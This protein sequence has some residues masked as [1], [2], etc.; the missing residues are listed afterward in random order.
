MGVWVL[1]TSFDVSFPGCQWNAKV[2]RGTVKAKHVKATTESYKANFFNNDISKDLRLPKQ[3]SSKVHLGVSKNRGTPKWMVYNGIPYWNDDLG[4]PL[5]SET[6]ISTFLGYFCCYHLKS[7]FVGKITF[8]LSW[9]PLQM[10]SGINGIKP[11]CMGDGGTWDS[12]RSPPVGNSPKLRFGKGNLRR[13]IL[14]MFW[15]QDMNRYDC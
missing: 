2:N 5:F 4:V 1:L 6:S 11:R 10:L 9:R 15:F 8:Q 7:K 12:D 14:F 13:Y 3:I